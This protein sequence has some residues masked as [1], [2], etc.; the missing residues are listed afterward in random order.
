MNKLRSEPPRNRCHTLE[1]NALCSEAFGARPS[2]D[3]TVDPQP[4]PLFSPLPLSAALRVKS[5]EYWLELGEPG[6]AMKELDRLPSFMR[7]HPWVVKTLVNT[8]G[9][10][11]K[12][13]P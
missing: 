10:L 7:K 5:A 3:E 6:Q 8:T 4:V 1:F 13:S 2:L 12:S 11:R 9:A